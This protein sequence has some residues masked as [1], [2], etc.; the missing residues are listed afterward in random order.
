MHTIYYKNSS[1]IET[2]EA[3]SIMVTD[4]IK[5]YKFIEKKQELACPRTYMGCHFDTNEVERETIIIVPNTIFLM[6]LYVSPDFLWRMGYH[7][8][9]SWL[10]GIKGMC[11]VY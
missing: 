6:W 3:C 9:R 5:W 1:N 2:N 8:K 11:G 4:I 7:C 10:W